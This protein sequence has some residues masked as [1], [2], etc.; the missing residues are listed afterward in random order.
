MPLVRRA[1]HPRLGILPESPFH[2]EWKGLP[3]FM[4]V[5]NQYTTGRLEDW[6]ANAV[7][8]SNATRFVAQDRAS[9]AAA[10]RAAEPYAAM[11]REAEACLAADK[12]L[13]LIF[14]HKNWCRWDDF[15][16][17]L[18]ERAVAATW[19]LPNV[20][21]A[22]MYE[23]YP[24]ITPAQTVAAHQQWVQRFRQRGQQYDS[25]HDHLFF[26][27]QKDFLEAAPYEPAS[28]MS[29]RIAPQSAGVD[30]LLGEG[31]DAHDWG[32]PADPERAGQHHG[33]RV[34]LVRDAVRQCEF[35]DGRL[36]SYDESKYP[37]AHHA[38]P[39]AAQ[40][41]R[42]VAN[43]Y[44]SG[45]PY[46]LVDDSYKSH[47]LQIRWYAEN[48]R[49]WDYRL[50]RELAPSRLPPYAP[51]SRPALLNPPGFVLGVRRP[52]KDVL[53]FAAVYRDALGQDPVQAEVWV[54]R[55]NDGRFSPDAG[56]GER[57]AMRAVSGTP[58]GGT[59]YTRRLRVMLEQP[60]R[61][62]FRF[63]SSAW[64]PP[65]SGE[66]VPEARLSAYSYDHWQFT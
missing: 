22:Y 63:A 9:A 7:P 17:E 23:W 24:G 29:A 39:T 28:S 3:F 2:F 36:C 26:M 61:Y 25:S 19:D 50:R 33:Y 10:V 62:V 15:S 37:P 48:R 43:L 21:Y 59:L 66:L 31:R 11:R 34:P 41:R 46:G 55:N 14:F 4:V 52:G 40:M 6:S 16:D 57:I 51:L 64:Y 47:L 65:Q 5:S 53:E 38:G 49:H 30:F 32:F 1:S 35:H 12:L 54:D 44:H 20:V 56:N 58:S 13:R 8:A 18:V 60:V 27:V 42:Q 45:Q